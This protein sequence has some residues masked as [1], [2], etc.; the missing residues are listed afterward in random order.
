MINAY[1]S[2]FPLDS[3]KRAAKFS[4]WLLKEDK[5]L[6]GDGVNLN[7]DMQCGE[8]FQ[9]LALFSSGSLSIEPCMPDEGV[10]EADDPKCSIAETSDAKVNSD[11]KTMKQKVWW[12]KESEPCNRRE[13]GFPGIK[14]RLKRKIFSTAEILSLCPEN[15]CQSSPLPLVEGRQEYLDAKTFSDSSKVGLS[16]NLLNV[17]LDDSLWESMT[18]YAARLASTD[19][20][21][22]QGLISPRLIKNAYS[23]I[24]HAGDQGLRMEELSEN[25]LMLGRLYIFPYFLLLFLFQ[26]K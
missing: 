9:L 4:D 19:F 25:I 2:P 6:I 11:E 13:K 24:H 22:D 5:N 10:G 1:S 14:M 12:R 15:N 8:V 3:G 17:S 26:E 21:R 23:A 20:V 16:T 7:L 18:T